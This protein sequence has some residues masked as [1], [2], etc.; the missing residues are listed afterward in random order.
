MCLGVDE[1]MHLK[2]VC[3]HARVHTTVCLHPRVC[4]PKSCFRRQ[5]PFS[6]PPP[7]SEEE[8]RILR[9]EQEVDESR[10]GATA[11]TPSDSGSDADDN[12]DGGGGGGR[13]GGRG[14]MGGC[15]DQ[16]GPGSSMARGKQQPRGSG[17]RQA[18]AAAPA[19]MG[20]L[21]G[22]GG[23]GGDGDDESI[24]ED[25]ATDGGDVSHAGSGL[26]PGFGAGGGGGG[27]AGMDGDEEAGDEEGDLL[28]GGSDDSGF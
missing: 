5:H 9:G 23:W 12:D 2:H 8:L 19:V 20:S 21:G 15:G 10:M 22:G 7:C 18:A 6:T 25:T 26:D 3:G 14:G 11:S 27:G 13:R 28:D 24:D 1:Y 4:R 17:G 16:W